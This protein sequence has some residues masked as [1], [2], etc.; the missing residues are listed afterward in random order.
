MFLVIPHDDASRYTAAAL[1]VNMVFRALTDVARQ[2]QGRLPVRVNA[3]L[4]EFGNLPAF[5]DFD[6]F[7]TVSAGMGIRLVLALQNIEQLKKHY[8]RTERTIRGNLGTWLFLRTSDLQTAKELSE[9]IGRY[10]THSESSQMPKVSFMT[11]STH[12]G[13]TSQ[14]LSLTGRE[15]VTADELMRWPADTVLVWQSGYPPAKL[16]LPD[17]SHWTIFDG[18]QVRQ[19]FKT[20]STT[21]QSTDNTKDDSGDSSSPLRGEEPDLQK[22]ASVMDTQPAP[23]HSVD[24]SAEAM[25]FLT[26]MFVGQD[27]PIDYADQP[28]VAQA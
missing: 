7:V 15:L 9:M 1:Y 10:T 19:E 6:Q 13:H 25:G 28:P 27:I 23:K 14:G 8:D 2:H 4:D 5:P 26:D 18:L 24:I 21:S 17:L 16:S 3:L 22:G 20:I 12:I 11:V